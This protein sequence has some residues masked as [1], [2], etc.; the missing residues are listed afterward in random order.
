MPHFSIDKLKI[1]GRSMLVVALAASSGDP[2]IKCSAEAGVY[3]KKDVP[4]RNLVN[5]VLELRVGKIALRI[6]I[7]LERILGNHV[8]L[9]EI[10]VVSAVTGEKKE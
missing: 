9:S 10:L 6:G 5:D 3:N 7:I 4:A 2:L 8:A 1:C